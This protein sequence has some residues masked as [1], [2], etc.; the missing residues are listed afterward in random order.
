[1]AV[2]TT[3]YDSTTDT[4]AVTITLASL[5]TSSTHIVGR[6]STIVDNTATKYLDVQ[7]FGQIEGGTTPTVDTSIRIYAWAPTKIA[8]STKTYPVASGT[9]QLGASD[10][11]AT[12][13]AYNRNAALKFLHQITVNAT[14]GNQYSFFI[15]SLAAAFGGVMPSWW[16]LFV[17]HNTVAALDSTGSNHWIHYTGITSTSA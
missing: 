16:G 2:L 6:Q 11:A 15:G 4:N 7:L 13:T 9:T 17:T 12:F 3:T 1:M 5:A 8:T 14:T 10:A